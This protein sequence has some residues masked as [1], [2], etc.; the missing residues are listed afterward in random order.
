MAKTTTA[1]K[2]TE[3][4]KQELVISPPNF[5]E[6]KFTIRG[7]SPYVQN[8]FSKKAFDAMKATQEAGST[9]KKNTKKEAKDFAACYEGAKHISTKGW[10]GIPA[11]AFRNA[12]ISACKIVGF[13][14]T[15]G[16]LSLFCE[17]DGFGEDGEPLVKITR[18][19]PACSLSRN[20]AA[21]SPQSVR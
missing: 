13:Q 11:P 17:P 10:C 2:K 12:L 16:K 19:I 21:S 1:T 18:S 14:M 6:A 7:N 4:G 3:T 20:D 9:A 5:K 15:K 8:K